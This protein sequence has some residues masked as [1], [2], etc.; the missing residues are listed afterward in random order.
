VSA[1][2]QT[3]YA[4]SI[5]V[6]RSPDQRL[7][8]LKRSLKIERDTKIVQSAVGL[9]DGVEGLRVIWSLGPVVTAVGAG[10]ASKLVTKRAPKSVLLVGLALTASG[11]LLLWRAPIESTYVV[12]TCCRHSSS[13]AYG[14][15]C[16]SCRCRSR[17]SPASR[18]RG[19]A[20]PPG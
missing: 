15:G 13:Q 5:P 3:G 7:R 9:R 4:G 6:A 19:P 20:W 8:W 16:R 2:F 1:A 11:M 14:S 17:H 12:E 10:V 18:R